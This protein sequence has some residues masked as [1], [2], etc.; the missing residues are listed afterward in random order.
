MPRALDCGDM[1]HPTDAWISVGC[2]KGGF[3]PVSIH[4]EPAIDWDTAQ[5]DGGLDMSCD[6]TTP[7]D[8]EC[9]APDVLTG[10]V[11]S[12]HLHGYGVV[13]PLEYVW[14]PSVMPP[15]D[16]PTEFD[17]RLVPGCDG[18]TLMIDE[19]YIPT[20][21][22]VPVLELSSLPVA[23][24]EVVPGQS[25]GTPDQTLMG[26][27]ASYVTYFASNPAIDFW[28]TIDLP[29]CAYTGPVP[30]VDSMVDC[31]DGQAI[32]DIVYVPTD[33]PVV[34]FNLNGTSIPWVPYAPGDEAHMRYVFPESDWGTTYEFKLCVGDLYHCAIQGG[35]VPVDCSPFQGK[36]GSVERVFCDQ[37][38]LPAIFIT[39]WPVDP[40]ITSILVNGNPVSCTPSGSTPDQASIQCPLDPSLMGTTVTVS[41][42]PGGECTDK[43][44]DVPNCGTQESDCVCRFLAPE[45]LSETSMGFGVNTC[46]TAATPVGL[47][48]GSVTASDGVNSYDCTI[49][50]VGQVYC[51]GSIPSAPGT[52]SVCFTEVGSASQKCCYFPD[53]AGTIPN[54]SNWQPETPPCSR[55]TT[56]DTC[57][58]AGCTPVFEPKMGT[59]IRCQ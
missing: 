57:R 52:L 34:Y 32:L 19:F 13:D 28:G 10:G 50:G 7:N 11:Y 17:T 5:I 2:P 6:Y 39:Y 35:T 45:C 59:F 8:Y 40:E 12:F 44:L 49:T 4:S 21:L 18:T 31:W 58:A 55:Y 25:R 22:G 20:D 14:D 30:K 23:M 1:D 27:T 33:K 47:V 46:V 56:A 42:C 16:C 51:G 29:D 26:T 48:P 24:A 53:F 38:F 43:T 41:I 36:T 15:E 3:I 37:N 54:C 9:I